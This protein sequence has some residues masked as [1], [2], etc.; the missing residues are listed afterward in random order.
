MTIDRRNALLLAAGMGLAA[1]TAARAAPGDDDAIAA[2]VEAFRKAQIALDGKALDKLCARELSYG[3]S[4]ARVE[5]KA[6]FIAGAT[7]AGRPKVVSLE[8]N[9]RMIRVVGDAAVVRFTWVS[10]QEALTDG[11]RSSNRLHVLMNW[12]RQGGEWKLLS[13]ASTKI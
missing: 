9:D 1:T 13:R 11:K 6:Q 5:D 2:N 8:W 12:I 3:H 10:E 4:D 7:A